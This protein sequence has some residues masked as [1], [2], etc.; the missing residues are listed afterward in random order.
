[1]ADIN[2]Q[3]RSSAAWI[4]LLAIIGAILLLW[5][6]ARGFDRE[7]EVLPGTPAVFLPGDPQHFATA[8]VITPRWQ[9]ASDGVPLSRT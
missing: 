2:V 3:R 8:D 6:L 7:P 4:W 5:A 9:R 1:M